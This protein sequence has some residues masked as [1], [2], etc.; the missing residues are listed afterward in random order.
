MKKILKRTPEEEEMVQ[1]AKESA[2][3][4]IISLAIGIAII[5]VMMADVKEAVY[6]L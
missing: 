5:A 3:I 6:G 2:I 4:T 1:I